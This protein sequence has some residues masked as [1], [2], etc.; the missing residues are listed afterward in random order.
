MLGGRRGCV[1]E[2]GGETNRGAWRQ[3]CC[4]NGKTRVADKVMTT[5]VGAGRKDRRKSR[6]PMSGW[7]S[8][9]LT[10]CGQGRNHG[11]TRRGRRL[12]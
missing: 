7:C 8:M 5:V 9:T 11:R 12:V 10:D 1:E 6:Q 3:V 4:L 2:L